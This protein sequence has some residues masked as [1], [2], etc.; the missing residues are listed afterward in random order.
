M[1]WIVRILGIIFAIVLLVVAIGALLPKQHTVTRQAVYHQPPEAIW[2]AITDYQKFP[3]WRKTVLRVEPFPSVNGNPAWTEI[4]DHDMKIPLQVTE[5]VP[6]QRLVTRIADPK[7]PWGGTWTTEIVPAPAG[8]T[9][10][11]TVRITEDGEVGNPIF[12]FMA[13]FVF[14]YT[15]T[16]DTYLKAL[17][18]KFGEQVT[19]QD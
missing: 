7:L 3:E 16:I 4:A 19:I 14:G 5:S 6:P 17:G 9:A 8:S 11:T 13:R 18:Q 12:R 1:K 10:A 15:S 2:Q